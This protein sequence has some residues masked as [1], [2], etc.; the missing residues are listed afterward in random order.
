MLSLPLGIKYAGWVISLSSLI[1]SA[2]VTK[3]TA[4]ILSNFVNVDSSLAKFADIAYVAYG[5]TGRLGTSI[6]FTL[7]LTAACIGLVILFA[8][9]LGSLIDGPDDFHWKILAGCILAPLKFF[10]LKW[11]SYTSFVGIVSVLSLILV[12]FVDG[13]LK[14]LDWDL[15]ST[16]CRRMPFRSIGKLYRLALA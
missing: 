3:Y 2:F 14:V 9:S 6:L 5:E 15:C 12:V 1:A 16:L 8:D 13:F 11:L 4:S 10:P 7:E